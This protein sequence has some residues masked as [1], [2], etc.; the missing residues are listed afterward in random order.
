M[1]NRPCLR[2]PKH[3]VKQETEEEIISTI[4]YEVQTPE[5]L[6]QTNYTLSLDIVTSR[7][8]KELG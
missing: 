2:T 6:A 8:S 5:E 4:R 7:S 3:K 1:C